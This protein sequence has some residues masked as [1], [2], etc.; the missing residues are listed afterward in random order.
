MVPTV[1]SFSLGVQHEIAAGIT[2]DVSY[3]GS[4]SR[5]LVTSRD[6]NAAPYGS[7]F[8]KDV[9]NPNCVDGN[10]NPV[11]AGGV[12]PN[13]QPDL[14]PEYA[15]AGYQLQRVLHVRI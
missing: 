15:A 7:A 6:I 4:L 8:Q 3:V 10:G 13:V 9:Q 11:F 5:H 12:V 14:Q 2:L 1:Y